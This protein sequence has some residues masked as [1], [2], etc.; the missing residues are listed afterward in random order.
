[1]APVIAEDDVAG[2]EGGGEGDAGEL[3]AD[4][5]VDGAEESALGEEVEELFLDLTDEESLLVEVE[6]RDGLT[7]AR[8]VRV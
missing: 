5:G 1:M 8:G 3:L 7:R 6:G 4:A 2:L